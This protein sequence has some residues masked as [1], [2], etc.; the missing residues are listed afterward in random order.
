[1]MMNKQTNIKTKQKTP[2]RNG[3]WKEFNKHAILISEGHYLNNEKHGLWREYYDTG[4]L[5]IE[6][7]FV[8]GIPHGRYAAYHPNGKVMSEGQYFNGMREGYFRVYDEDGQRIRTLLFIHNHQI[9]DIEELYASEIQ[10]K[11]SS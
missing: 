6:E 9:E 10:G 7:N 1:M 4:E 3:K 5:M 11:Q 2:V 8:H